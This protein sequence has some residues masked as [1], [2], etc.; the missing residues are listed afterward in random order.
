MTNEPKADSSDRKDSRSSW[1]GPC[2]AVLSALSVVPLWLV[3]IPP[4]QDLPNHLLKV[5][6]FRKYLAGD[7][8]AREI[9]ALNLRPLSNYTFYVFL[10]ITAPLFGLVGASKVFASVYLLTLPAAFFAWVRRANPAGLVLSLAVP[11]LGYN[12]FF[13]KGNLN[14]CLSL[15]IYLAWLA[16]FARPERREVAN[17][18]LLSSLSILLYFTHGL[19]F[20]ALVGVVTCV[21]LADRRRHVAVRALALLPG[22]L[23]FVTQLLVQLGDADGARPMKPIFAWPDRTLLAGAFTWLLEPHGPSWTRGLALIWLVVVLCAAIATGW[24]L[25]SQLRERPRLA[26]LLREER[27][28]VA[29]LALFGALLA[30]PVRL[31]DW[32]HFRGRFFPLVALTLLGCLR[33]PKGHASSVVAGA[34]LSVGALGIFAQ[35]AFELRHGSERVSEYLAGASVIESGASVLP[36]HGIS[37]DADAP[38][39]HNLHS[40]GYYQLARDTWS[41]YMQAYASYMPV[42]YR[43]EPWRSLENPGPAE[44]PREDIERAADCF[45][46]VVVWGRIA[47]RTREAI[48]ELYEPVLSQENLA[49]FANRDGIRRRTPATAPACREA[50]RK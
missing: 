25:F 28:L 33:L 41:P 7:A 39:F 1:V 38:V 21:V 20:L 2:L 3:D 35:N 26:T 46:Y 44:L 40:W 15:A 8:H 19:V 31:E 42:V 45:D 48:A 13:V 23:L 16:V 5:D 36:V 30:A 49:V 10:L 27:F 24:S 11:A 47:S 34:L 43:D 18:A 22:L 32:G 50:A 17:M 14:F 29:G 37:P 6:V 12:L 9:Y 4:M